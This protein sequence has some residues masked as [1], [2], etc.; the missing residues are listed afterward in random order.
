M[1][2][3]CGEFFFS[4]SFCID[5]CVPSACVTERGMAC[6]AS[7]VC[8]GF[9]VF[10]VIP[11]MCFSIMV[12]LG[13]DKKQIMY[14]HYPRFLRCVCFTGIA[15]SVLCVTGSFVGYVCVASVQDDFVLPACD[16][17][18]RRVVAYTVPWYVFWV[19]HWCTEY[20]FPSF[21]FPS[22]FFVARPVYYLRHSCP[23]PS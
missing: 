5:A 6:L 12:G 15:E 10:Y 7:G 13:V 17:C 8:V 23:A 4:F 2:L 16:T 11:G 18:L 9:P 20:Y 19:S 22:F 3:V 14:V 1:S 21:C